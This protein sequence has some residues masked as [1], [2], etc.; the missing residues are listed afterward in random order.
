[1]LA[2]VLGKPR[3]WVLAHPEAT[4]TEKQSQVWEE[5]LRLL[6]RGIPLPYILGHWEFFG[7]DFI[8]TP[9]VLIPRPETELLVEQAIAGCG[10]RIAESLPPAIHNP[11]SE[12][13]WAADVGTGSGCIAISLAV[14]LPNLQ[15]IATDISLPALQVA[16]R[17]A[18]KHSVAERIHFVQTD[19][20][21]PFLSHASAPF[22]LI[23]ANLPYIP[24]R[25]LR[26]LPVFG[27]EP[28]L[29]LDGGVDGLDCIRRILD[30]ARR[31]LAPDGLLLLEIEE[32]QG[33]AARRLAGEA[34][35]EREVGV[36]PDL[37]GRDRLLV[38]RTSDN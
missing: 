22:H 24:T 16:R 7:L 15:V 4:L 3:S 28:T 35:P 5:S 26:A 38:V 12:I 2:H 36:L 27:R 29:A 20:I 9:A 6:E 17:N 1:M 25:T 37:A 32:S 23:C 31:C 18:H 21:S 13:A 8:V 19:L 10:M 34:F 30:D 11:N 14:L 33:E